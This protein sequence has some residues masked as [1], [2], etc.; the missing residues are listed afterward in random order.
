M[1]VLDAGEEFSPQSLQLIAGRT[2]K[3]YSVRQKRRGEFWEGRY[4]EKREYDSYFNV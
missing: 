4:Y 2:V 1:L 3:E